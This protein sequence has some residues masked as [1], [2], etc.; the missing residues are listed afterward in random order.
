MNGNFQ[1]DLSTLAFKNREQL[2]YF[3]KII[4]RIQQEIILSGEN[5][6][7]TRLS[8]NYIKEL[9][10]SE[11]LKALI[12]PKMT[13]LITFLENN[14]KYSVYTGGNIHGL[15]RYLNMIVAT[16][17]LT[18]LGQRYHH[19]GP[20]SSINNDTAALQTFISA[21]RMIQKII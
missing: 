5:V 4:F 12:T 15:Y 13:D 7:S 11:K 17:I 14:I 19:F 9:S 16:T 2:E 21:L 18:N 8:L 20:S 1:C 3:H 10:N 6:S